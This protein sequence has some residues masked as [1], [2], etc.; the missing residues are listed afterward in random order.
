MSLGL[1]IADAGREL[2]L[3]ASRCRRI[4]EGHGH[5]RVTLGTARRIANMLGL[6]LQDVVVG[7]DKPPGG[8]TMD[9]VLV[10][11]ALFEATAA[12]TATDLASVFGWTLTRAGETVDSLN[13]RLRDRGVSVA[14]VRGGYKLVSR[15]AVLNARQRKALGRRHLARRSLRAPAARLLLDAAFGRLNGYDASK[16]KE[17]DRLWLAQLSNQGLVRIHGTR[18]AL[19]RDVAYSL[20][21]TGKLSDVWRETTATTGDV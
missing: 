3:G 9:D 16:L 7:T 11:A 4:E 21:L 17:S 10:E 14:R 20:G 18:V 12:V 2:N 6:D 1:S 8:S 13:A 15:K 19:D 5:G